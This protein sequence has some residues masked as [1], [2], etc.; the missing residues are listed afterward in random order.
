MTKTLK[1]I[2]PTLLT[3]GIIFGEGPR[4][5]DGKLYLSDMLG[6]KIYAIDDAGNKE[7]VVQVPN[8]P[9][10][11]CFAPDGTLIHCSM[12]D[13]ALYKVVDG[14]DVLYKDLS[15]LMTGYCGDIVMDDAGRIYVDDVGARLHH[16][17]TRR[18]GR[19]LIVETDGSLKSAVENIMFPN[20]IVI[21]PDGK[22]LLLGESHAHCIT[23][24]DIAPD[25]SLH[26]RRVWLDTFDLIDYGVDGDRVS[27]PWV[28]GLVMDAEEGVWVSMLKADCFV[29]VDKDAKPTHIIRVHGDATACT[30]GGPD[31]KTLFM[32]CNAI[33]KDED[34]FKAMTEGRSKGCVMTARVD[35]PK[36]ETRP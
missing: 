34:I 17:E 5:R 7:V 36:G 19:V 29:R 2:E 18:P 10:G 20:G 13:Q 32:A 31:G 8:Q 22:T 11:I 23:R 21:S 12:F 25:G 33:P 15:P 16:G 26:N 1:V 14:E 24:F 30:L 28:D 3:E 27:F 6:K 4:W 9:N 35:I